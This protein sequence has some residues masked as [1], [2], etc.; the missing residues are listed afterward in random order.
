MNGEQCPWVVAVVWVAIGWA[1]MLAGVDGGPIECV[2]FC[3][4]RGLVDI[5]AL[6]S[7]AWNRCSGRAE[8]RVRGS[9]VW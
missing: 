6:R 2:G 5:G 3:T 1:W 8:R 9:C 7:G 4:G